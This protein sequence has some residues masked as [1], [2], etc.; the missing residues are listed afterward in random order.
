L[1]EPRLPTWFYIALVDPATLMA[2][3]SQFS[4][5]I[6]NTPPNENES[7]EEV[8]GGIYHYE[9]KEVIHSASKSLP[10]IPT[11]LSMGG[12]GS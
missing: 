10:C 7:T 8:E 9:E 3:I 12:V 4:T 6:S 2:S 11:L 5:Y 1:A